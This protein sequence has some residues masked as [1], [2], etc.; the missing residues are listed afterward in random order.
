MAEINIEGILNSIFNASGSV[1]GTVESPGFLATQPFIS[2]GITITYGGIL[3]VIII[4][5]ATFLIAKLLS[6]LVRR[7]FVGKLDKSNLSFMEKLTRWVIYFFGFLAVS[8]PLGIDFSGLMVAGGIVAV[9]IGFASQNTL[10]NFIAGLLLMFERPVNLGDNISVKGTQGYVEDIGLM[11]TTLRTY[12]GI[13]VR[14]PNESMFSSDIINYV[15]H[16]ARRFEYT[17]T[18]RYKDDADKATKIIKET[19]DKHPYALKSPS[20]SVFVDDLGPNGSNLNIRI[21]SP[22]GYWW[23]AKTELLWKIVQA[24]RAGGIVIPFD[25]NVLWFGNPTALA[26]SPQ[27]KALDK[28]M[29]G[30]ASAP[31]GDDVYR[32]GSVSGKEQAAPENVPQVK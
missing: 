21:W 25:Q 22:S 18:I 10:S 19:I 11:S 30:K 12:Q 8:G 29:Y 24:L 5:I 15:A 2:L 1:A 20:P 16:I 13:Y 26:G 31:A 7:M 32:Q 17:I 4:V 28:A 27:A 23:D 14:V 3:T 9:A 6:N